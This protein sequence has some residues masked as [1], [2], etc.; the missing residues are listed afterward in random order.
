MLVAMVTEPRWPGAG[1]DL[2]LLLVILGVEDGMDDAGL[3]QHLGNVLAGLHRDGADEDG[4]ALVVDGGDFLEDGVEFFALGL[5][6][7][8]VGVAAGD[9][10]VGGDDQDAQFVNVQ[11]FATPRS[12]RCRSCR[13]VFCKGESNFEW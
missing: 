7:R 9:R 11:E 13:R 12:R 6:D 3:L 2:G 5:I 1:D 4:A 8:V 10:A